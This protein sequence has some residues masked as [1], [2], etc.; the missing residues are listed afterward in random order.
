MKVLLT[1]LAVLSLFSSGFARSFQGQATADIPFP[2]SRPSL[3]EISPEA[4]D[5]LSQRVQQLVDEDE[6]VGAEVLIIRNG[7]SILHKSYGWR[8]REAKVPMENGSVFCVRSMTKPF[9]GASVL[10]LIEAGKI[11]L[12][13][14]ICRYL[15]AF[16]VDGM[17]SITID[18]LLTHTSGLPMSAIMAMDLGDLSGIQDV[19]TLGGKQDLEFE[20]GTSFNYSDQGT[21]TLT[22]L[23]EIVS[24]ISAAEFVQT[25][26]LDPLGMSESATVMTADHPLRAR[27]CAKYFGQ[28]GNWSPFWNPEKPPLF[29][30]F[31][32]SQGLYS[33]LSDYARFTQFWLNDGR[34]GDQQLLSQGLVQK[35]LTPGG[36]PLGSPTGLPGLRAE[37]GSLMQLWTAPTT[38]ETEGEREVIA[39]GHTGSDGTHAWVFPEQNAMAFYFT[40]SRGTLSGF[41]VEEALG[42]LFLGVPVVD[43][44]H[45]APP[46]EQYLGYYKEH[47]D[48]S[49]SAIVRDGDD[50]AIEVP[51]IALFPLDYIGEDQWKLRGPGIV[52]AF[53]RSETGEVLGYTRGDEYEVRFTPSSELPSVDE[54]EALTIKAH[55]LDLLETAGPLRITSK[56]EFL[57]LGLKGEESSL[58]AW[59]DFFR[60]DALIGKEFEHM[61]VSGDKVSYHSPQKPVAVIDGMLAEQI[62]LGHHL[63]RL[64]EWRRWHPQMEVIQ[65]LER[66]D[67]VIFLVR[68][69]DTSAPAPTLIIEAGSGIVLG[70]DSI[71]FV[72]GIGR[73]GQHV[74]FSDYRDVSGMR[75]PFTTRAKYANRMIG[76]VMSTVTDF[77]LGVELPAGIFELE[78]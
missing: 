4:L 51:G 16:D 37:Y 13:D 60:M 48:D 29:H 9:I 75:L 19:A 23:I 25:R 33:T 63:A 32:G 44:R 76:T 67:R 21:D 71:P 49:Y 42:E 8:D 7:L 57:T 56:I 58:Y 30:F 28:R 61:A 22:A 40:Q 53:D 2:V 15:P 39:F 64:G 31:L 70:E 34:V 72:E 68:A 35:A 69:G 17:R 10:M 74:R 73:L 62:R 52:L 11:K 77:E 47:D 18:H 43:L 20:P 65:Q 66:G 54:L 55:R 26:L 6:I 3:Q 45:T 1:S 78:E 5:K 27:V 36:Y 41:A 12:D 24:G 38:P 14:P 50:L 59:P 46:M